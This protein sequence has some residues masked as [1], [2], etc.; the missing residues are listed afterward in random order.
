[1]ANSVV[2]KICDITAIIIVALFVVIAALLLGV[3]LFGYTPYVILSPSMTG[4]YNPNDLVYT[5]K[6]DFDDIQVG[7]VITFKYYNE[8]EKTEIAITHRVYSI[9]TEQHWLITKGDANTEPDF[10]PVSAEN[11]LGVV[12]FSI[13]KLGRLSLYLSTASGKFAAVA[14]LLAILLITSIP[15]IVSSLQHKND[16][17]EEEEEII[18]E[19]DPEDVDDSPEDEPLRPED[20]PDYND[21]EDDN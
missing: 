8:E 4:T 6:A 19:E 1:M 14:V 18:Y 13:P 10:A 20:R 9:N 15:D 2:K 11:V 21:S 7:D 3:R 5:R 12:K 16:S 17:E